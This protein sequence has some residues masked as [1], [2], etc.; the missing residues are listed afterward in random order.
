MRRYCDARCVLWFAA[1]STETTTSTSLFILSI[2]DVRIV[3]TKEPSR[4]PTFWKTVMKQARFPQRL[5]LS[6]T[7]CGLLLQTA[8]A[9]ITIETVPV[10][11]A[12]NAADQVYFDNSFGAVAFNYGIGKYEVTL[13][14]YCAFLNAVGATDTYGLYNMG[15]AT[16]QKIQ[17]IVRSGVSGNYIY[18]VIGSGNRPVTYVNWFDAARF[19]NWLHNEQPVGAQ[20]AGTTETGSYTLNG[21]TSGLGSARNANWKYGLPSENEWYKS[22]YHQP[23]AQGGDTDDYWFYPTKSNDIPNSRNGSVS[24]ANSANFFRNVAPVDGVNDGYAVSGSTSSPTGNVLADVGA[25]SLAES[26]Y[27]TFDQAGSVQEWIDATFGSQRIT[28]GGGWSSS[29]GNHLSASS[30]GTTDPV[31]EGSPL[32]FRVVVLLPPVLSLAQSGNTLAFSWTGNFKLQAQTNS[33]STNW[34]DYPSGGSSPVNV[35]I[36]P[37]NPAVFFRLSS[38]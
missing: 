13:N 19:A 1:A 3:V 29:G 20:V 35:T 26:F 16:D 30:R 34:T 31:F 15:M 28:R 10:G 9:L 36:N 4:N 24:D 18:S 27:G 17:G 14:Q 33:I 23:L 37:A 8:S 38:P 12:G 7:A 32:G 11:N 22:A 21:A 2:D 25:F 5:G 6:I